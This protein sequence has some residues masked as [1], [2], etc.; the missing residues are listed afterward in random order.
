[1]YNIKAMVKDKK[2]TFVRYRNNELIYK[3]E[4]GFEFPIHTSDT[5]NGV[6]KPEDKAIT[7][8]RWIRKQILEIEKESEQ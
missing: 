2:V 5:G 4:C 3:T 6:F 7:F 1:M 8:M